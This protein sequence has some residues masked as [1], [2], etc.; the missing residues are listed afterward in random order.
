MKA[1]GQCTG[2]GVCVL[3]PEACIEIYDPVCGC[4]GTTYSNDCFAASASV[5]VAYS[6]ECVGPARV[7]EYSNSGCLQRPSLSVEGD[8][9]P[10]C[11]GDRMEITVEGLLRL[12][13]IAAI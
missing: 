6:G 2:E 3:R 9:Y 7:G 1:P 10:W 4:D 12:F 13:V 5:S 11:G 8:P